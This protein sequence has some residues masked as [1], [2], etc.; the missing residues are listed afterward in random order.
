MEK[1]RLFSCLIAIFTIFA[2]E[3][4]HEQ[5]TDTTV[6]AMAVITAGYCLYENW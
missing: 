5:S 2:C 1:I 4:Q 6:T 3:K